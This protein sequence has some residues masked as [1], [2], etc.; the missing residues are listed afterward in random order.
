MSINKR[1]NSLFLAE[2]WTTIYQAFKTINFA[3]YD[4]DTIRAALIDYIRINYP[5]DFNDWIDSSE[6]VSIIELLSYLASSLAFRIDL[7][8]RENFLDTATRRESIVRLA[9]MLSYNSR[10]CVASQGLLKLTRVV[11]DQN[12]Y[13]SNGTNL[14]N[15]PVIWNDANNPD[16]FEQ[17]VL[18]LNAAFVKSNPFG[19]PVKSGNVGNISTDR[20]DFDNLLTTT[21]AF[22]FS[23]DVNGQSMSFEFCNVDFT[24]AN[25]GSINVGSL[26]YFSEKTPS[27]FN[28]YSIVYRSDGNGNASVNTGFFALFKQGTLGYVD[29]LLDTP[30]PN[31]IIDVSALNVNQSDVWVQTINDSGIP[32]QEWTKVPAIVGSNIVYNSVNRLTRNIYQV[33]TRD[34]NGVDAVSIKFGDGAFG[35]I[36]VGRVRVYYRTSNNQTYTILPSDMGSIGLT[37]TYKADGG[38]VNNVN[39]TFTLSSTVANSLARESSDSIRERASAV[40]YTQNRMVNGEDYN[41][42]P[43]RSSEALK[44]KSVNRVYSGMSRYIDINDPTGRYQNTKIFSDDGIL[45]AQNVQSYQEIPESLNLNPLQIIDQ[46]IQPS[47]SGTDPSQNSSVLLRDFYLEQF[48]ALAGSNVKWINGT[49]SNTTTSQGQFYS[50]DAM[51]SVPDSDQARTLCLREG[52]YLKFANGQWCSIA[53]EGNVQSN[54]Q[55]V[56]SAKVPDNTPLVEII[57]SFVSTL[58][59]DERSAIGDAIRNRQ[60]FGIRYDQFSAT[61]TIIIAQNLAEDAPFSLDTE[62]NNT[63]TNGNS[64]WLIQ[65]KYFPSSG[66]Q[67][68][69]RGLQYVFESVAD[70]RFYFV[71]QKVV[72]NSTGIVQQ[73]TVKILK[74]NSQPTNSNP[75]GTDLYWALQTQEILDDGYR[76]PR[77]VRVSFW[78]SNRDG[79]VDNP[80]QFKVLVAPD[81]PYSVD[82]NTGEITGFFPWVFWTKI[83]QSGFLYWVPTTVDRVF[84][85]YLKMITNNPPQIGSTF[86]SDGEI[87]YLKDE[88]SFL[89]Y[90][91]SPPAFLD[92][93]ADYLGAPGRGNLDYM[94]QHWVNTSDR[95]DPA[96]MNVIDTFVLTSSYD[97]AMR[98]WISKGKASDPMPEPATPE[99]LRITFADFDNYRMMSDQIVW[100]PVR[101]KLLFGATADETVRATFKIVKNPGVSITDSELKSRVIQSVDNYFS[102]RN[103]DFGQ[104]FFF[105]ELAAYIHQQNPTYLSSVVIVPLNATSAFGDLFEIKCDPD[106]IFISSAR[107]SDVQIVPALTPAELRIS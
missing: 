88:N 48:P 97:T 89:R 92:I 58:T 95:I 46:Y 23:A 1:Q 3:A 79:I 21:F 42:F 13:D 61:W 9:R 60:N 86:Y 41:V 36:P 43:L 63:L 105:T 98:D 104:S 22:P 7:N 67:M 31:R 35:N 53:D 17:F 16:W 85:N 33:I 37:L 103:W 106:E 34:S 12:I 66:W 51:I 80:E 77:R 100:H 50:G 14:A 76:D 87:I 25:T 4:Y 40:Y 38:S 11:T 8:I 65:M 91:A 47:L 20:Y 28:A 32:V 64:S 57:P 39:M 5:E 27:I 107:V 101:Y 70:V 82:N 6:F 72:D 94:W 78:D 56:L 30:I 62:N 26:G 52:T 59:D 55:V 71:N 74:T 68:K 93:S 45:S 19:E 73:D 24:T 54:Y 18:V 49:G 15:V 75:I 90:Q 44:V 83:N 84:N 29:Y 10:R 96:I 81:A 69:T 2:D 99:S 102:I